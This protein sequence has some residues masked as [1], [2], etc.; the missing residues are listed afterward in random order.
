MTYIKSPGYPAAVTEAQTCKWTVAREA[1]PEICFVRVDF[2]EF[3]V[4]GPNLA[5]AAAPR[6]NCEMDTLT[7]RY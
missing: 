2:V 6:G 4:N 7:F 3:S 1:D 5:A